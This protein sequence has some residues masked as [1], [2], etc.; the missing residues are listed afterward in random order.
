MKIDLTNIK[1]IIFDLGNVLLNL[2][3]KASIKAFHQLGL[4]PELVDNSQ[5]Y[6]DPVFYKFGT[7]RI[8]PTEFR[9][10]LRILLQNTQATDEQLDRTWCAMILNI[11]DKRVEMLKRLGKKYRLY[12]FSNTNQ[13]HVEK[14]HQEFFHHHKIEFPT[15]FE[16][17]F[18]SH[19]IQEH[20][21]ELKSYLKVIE[22]ANINPTETLFIDDLEEN[23]EGAKKAGLK[24]F[25][26]KPDM[27]ITELLSVG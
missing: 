1:N 19:E 16:K 13:I 25:W 12:L 24:T 10:R 27:E 5:A 3:F 20:K 21:P 26:L 9:K 11:P 23:I 8:S 14:L 18:Y 4:N 6:S 22:L 2:D 15:L 17:I 7:G